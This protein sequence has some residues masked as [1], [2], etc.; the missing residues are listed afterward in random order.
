MVSSGLETHWV[1]RNSAKNWKTLRTLGFSIIRCQ[2]FSIDQ[3]HHYQN[4]PHDPDPPRTSTILD[5]LVIFD[6]FILLTSTIFNI[7]IILMLI[8]WRKTTRRWWEAG[9]TTC[10]RFE[11][12]NIKILQMIGERRKTRNDIFFKFKIYQILDGGGENCRSGGFFKRSQ[13]IKH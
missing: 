5:I 7:L 1:A 12:E 6:I 3:D 11:R 2:L 13:V 10:Q 8:R 4:D 9:D